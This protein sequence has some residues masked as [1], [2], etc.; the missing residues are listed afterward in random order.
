MIA[1]SDL[2]KGDGL[3]L[4]DELNIGDK[5]DGLSI[6]DYLA[7]L[8]QIFDLQDPIYELCTHNE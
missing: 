8:D 3:V 7:F 1:D 5:S 4:L 2:E 6:T